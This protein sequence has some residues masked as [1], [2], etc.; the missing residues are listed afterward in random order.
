[1]T[2]VE[3]IPA[4]GSAPSDPAQ[5]VPQFQPLKLEGQAG[6]ISA[7]G[8]WQDGFWTV[9]YRRDLVTPAQTLNDTVFNRTV[10]FSVHVFDGVERIDESSES[11][12]LFLR[13]MEPGLPGNDLLVAGESSR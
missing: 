10:Q 11:G 1:M 3:Q 13:F 8:H 6:E 9:E 7:K 2:F 4:P 5:T 12:R